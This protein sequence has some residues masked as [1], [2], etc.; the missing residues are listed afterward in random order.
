MLEP[1]DDSGDYRLRIISAIALAVRD[2]LDST[3][4]TARLGFLIFA[5]IVATALATKIL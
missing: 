3:P 1:P 4:R 5:V 2:V